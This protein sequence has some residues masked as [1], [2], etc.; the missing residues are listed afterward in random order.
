MKNLMKLLGILVV[1]ASTFSAMAQEEPLDRN[2]FQLTPRV[3]YDFPTYNN[4]TPYIDYKGGLDLG[5]SLDYYWNWFGVGADV[6]YIKNK[7]KSTYPTADLY[8]ADWMTPIDSFDLTEDKITRFFYGIGPNFQYRNRM[9]TFT[10][11][12]NTRFG[13][14]S[15]KGG[16][17]YLEGSSATPNTYPLNFHAGYDDSQVLTA[18]GQLRFTYLLNKNWGINLGAYYM[19]HFNV[20]ELNE[21]GVS[22]MYQPFTSYTENADRPMTLLDRE[23]M[24]REEPCDCDISSV[25]LFAGITYKFT[26]SK[27][28]NICPVCEEDHFP[29]CCATCGCG[30]TVTARDKFTGETLPNTDVVLT[31]LNG[32]IVQSGTTNSYGVVVFNEVIEGDYIVKGKLYNISLEEESITKAEFKN[33]QKESSGIQKVIFYGDKN[34]ILKG[35]VVECNSAEGI[36]S[37]DILLKD[38]INPGEKHTLSDAKG[39]FMF[40]LKQASNYTLNGKKEGY[41]S[42][43]VEISTSSYNRDNTLFIDFEM[44]VDPC[45]KAI[46]LDNINFDLDKADILPEAIADLQ[47]IV[48]LM[49]DNPNIQVEMSSHTDSQ[50]SDEYNRKLSQRRADA[51]VAYIASQGISKSRLIARG[52]GESE[53]KNTKCA[54]NVPCTDDEHRINRRTEFKVVCF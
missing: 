12:L 2:Y 16:R 45:G 17:T 3:G 23:P 48:K 43:D 8:E 25:G 18:K 32:N 5:L 53:L 1:F 14:A 10:A 51:T 13:L 52:A 22:A 42:N 29:H 40:H 30:V 21:S 11:E 33:C 50:G 31:D 37:V 46:K 38:N 19:R 44:C 4:N 7:P 54:N 27:K 36:Q 49:N 35:N 15:I 47:R 9:G 28:E 34:F 39:D 41:Y 26:K 24:F 20:E 6:D